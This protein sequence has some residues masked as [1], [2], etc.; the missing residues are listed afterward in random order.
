M[1]NIGIF[2]SGCQKD[3]GIYQWTLNILHALKDYENNYRDSQIHLFYFS[4]YDQGG[5]IKTDFPNFY[6]HAIG[7]TETFICKSLRKIFIAVPFLVAG[8]RYFYPLNLLCKKEHIDL[9]VFPGATLEACLY[10]K[11]QVFMFTDIAHIFYPNF[12]E[13]SSG[14]KLR[15]RHILFKYG[16]KNAG[17][18]AV[19]S[20][21]LRRDIAINYSADISKADVLY[22]ALPKTIEAVNGK[23]DEDTLDFKTKLPAKYIFYPAQLWEHKNHKNLLHA[24]SLIVKEN[25]DLRLVLTGARKNGDERIFALI[26]DLHLQDYVNY[27]GYVPDKFMPVLYKN[28]SMLVM[29]TYF[30]PTNIPALEAFYYGCPV[31]HSNLPGVAEQVA[32]AAL[33]FDPDSAQDIAEKISMMLD[34]EALR[35]EKIRKGYERIKILS[36]ENYKR[37]FFDIIK[38]NLKEDMGKDA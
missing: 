30:G 5:S 6:S 14:G 36:Y 35:A 33:L 20:E 8:L 7:K 26:K 11:R 16:I 37:R 24:M 25:R 13:V 32:D 38:K 21:Q 17:C 18:I 4:E 3:G 34:N 29:P 15:L 28:A 10:N 22:Q 31:L 19:D 9:M 2:L 23:L 27:L 12:P 1:Y